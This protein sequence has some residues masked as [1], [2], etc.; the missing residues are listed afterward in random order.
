MD[1]NE[2]VHLAKE[3]VRLDLLRDEMLEKLQDIAGKHTFELL[4]RVQKG[5]VGS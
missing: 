2:A 1:Q 3:I 4:R 5:G